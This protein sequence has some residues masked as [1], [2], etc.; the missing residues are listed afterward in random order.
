MQLSNP[1]HLIEQLT[2][3]SKRTMDLK[4]SLLLSTPLSVVTIAVVASLSYLSTGQASSQLPPEPNMTTQVLP[5][6][7]TQT[8]SQSLTKQLK[9][10]I[11]SA[12]YTLNEPAVQFDYDPNLFVLSS[13]ESTRPDLQP[14][15]RSSTSLWSKEDY[16]AI[17][18]AGSELGDFPDKLRIAVYSNPDGIPA[19]DWISGRPGETLGVEIEDIKQV[20]DTAAWSFSYRSLFEYFGIIFQAANGQ[21]VVITAYTHPDD[22]IAEPYSTALTTIVSS[23]ELLTP[24]SEIPASE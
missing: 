18:N 23:L 6:E 2:T 3:P 7:A 1:S 24:A 12:T 19:R 16:L 22:E 10:E 5:N 4:R 9:T 17:Q 21:M 20:S 8:L 14:L 13:S 11:G 15:L